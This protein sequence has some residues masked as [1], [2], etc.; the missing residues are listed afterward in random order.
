MIKYQ[1]RYRLT[2]RL[3]STL[4]VYKLLVVGTPIYHIELKFNTSI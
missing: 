1:N 2:N 3:R 4:Q